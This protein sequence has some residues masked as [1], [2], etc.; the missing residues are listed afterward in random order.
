VCVCTV[1]AAVGGRKKQAAPSSERPKPF[2]AR[3]YPSAEIRQAILVRG[4]PHVQSLTSPVGAKASAGDA[5][6][7]PSR[8]SVPAA[9]RWF[10][11]CPTTLRTALPIGPKAALPG[12]RQNLVLPQRSSADCSR[13]IVRQPKLSVSSRSRSVWIA[14]VERPSAIAQRTSIG[15]REIP[16]VIPQPFS[17]SPH[18]DVRPPLDH[19]KPTTPLSPD[20]QLIERQRGASFDGF[21]FADQLS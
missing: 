15:R 7:Q 11:G 2:V 5:L 6:L 3:G 13:V 17:L 20:V 1:F 16:R 18:L 21:S 10:L 9:I 19:R 14:A 4:Y 12:G 8:R